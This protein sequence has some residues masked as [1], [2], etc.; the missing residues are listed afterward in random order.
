[1][2]VKELEDKIKKLEKRDQERVEPV[3]RRSRRKK[4][5]PD[6]RGSETVKKRS[7]EARGG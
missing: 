5:R 1:M 2:Q 3:E 7:P 4:A 6:W